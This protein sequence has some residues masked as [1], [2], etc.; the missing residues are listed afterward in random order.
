M[1]VAFLSYGGMDASG[2]SRWMQTMA[3]GIA[4]YD[5][6]VDYFY[7][8][9]APDLGSAYQAPP[10][11][12]DRLE[13]MHNTKVR[14]LEYHLK[15]VDSRRIANN[16]IKTDIWTLF[17][18]SKYE[19]VQVA[20]AGPMEYPFYLL[21]APVVEFLSLGTAVD[22]GPNIVWS[23]HCSEW[24]RQAWLA[25]GGRPESSS[26]ISNPAYP[27]A[28][29]ENLR[30][31]LGI[32]ST[33][34]VAGFH[35]RSDESIFSSIPLKAFASTW[36]PGRYFV[37]MGGGKR[38]RKQAKELGLKNVHFLPHSGDAGL[39]SRFLNT[40]DIYAHGRADGETFGT[41]LAEAI[42]HGKPCLTHYV[43]D[44]NNAQGE[45]IGPAG[46]CAQNMMEY[47]D[48]LEKL[49]D[50]TELRL[51][52]ASAAAP[53][54]RQC[55]VVEAAVKKLYS[56][57]SALLNK[58]RKSLFALSGDDVLSQSSFRLTT[59]KNDREQ[60][61]R[62]RSRVLR[63]LITALSHPRVSL[64][65]SIRKL[66]YAWMKASLRRKLWKHPFFYHA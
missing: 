32:P 52:F 49:F 4:R 40:L 62:K 33:A 38:Y 14:L 45:T 28:S 25:R 9:P 11:D 60:P 65:N 15:V 63:R 55:F 41:V 53:Y 44:G 61:V 57:Y 19:L 48:W 24:Q 29:A 10:L 7:C 43:E 31:E 59:E 3:A 17:D 66:Y 22:N 21:E 51:Q 1:R 30:A 23:I 64:R 42:I 36:K 46:I 20:K 18:A 56:L 8:D 2:T 16:W 47:A 13:W 5:S 6:E 37:L 54:A 27:P 34:V 39:L 35:Q 26:V 12:G 50:S 58:Q